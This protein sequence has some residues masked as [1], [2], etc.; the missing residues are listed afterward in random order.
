[1]TRTA[2]FLCLVL[3]ALTT[4]PARAQVTGPSSAPPAAGNPAV[5]ALESERARRL[6]EL[7]SRLREAPDARI[8]RVIDRE[9]S[10]I[11]A[12]SGS[13]TADLLMARATQA[14]ER[15]DQDLSLSLLD[16]VIDLYP[17]YVEAWSRRATV[18][19]ARKELG[20]AVADIEQVLKRE[21][22]H[23]GALAGLGMILQQLGD[24]KQALDVFRR[25]LEIH[26][27]LERLPD[28]VRRLQP[29][30]DGTEL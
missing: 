13:D 24:D 27:Y 10:L 9:I 26:P 5:P 16:A 3:T 4:N 23:Y 18:Y 14:F 7:F 8:A 11:L 12:R 15:Q 6:D 28:I 21:P 20:R 2:V 25:A 29:K 19:F 22:R 30:V 17:D 1:M